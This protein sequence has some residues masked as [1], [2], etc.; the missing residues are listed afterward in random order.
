MAF[1]LNLLEKQA[2]FGGG[3]TNICIQKAILE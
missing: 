1:G 3:F 2:G